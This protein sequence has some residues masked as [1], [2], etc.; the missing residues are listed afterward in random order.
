MSHGTIEMTGRKHPMGN[1]ACRFPHLPAIRPTFW[2]IVVIENGS[3]DNFTGVAFASHRRHNGSGGRLT[4]LPPCVSSRD[5]RTQLNSSSKDSK[6]SRSIGDKRNT[7]S[8]WQGNRTVSQPVSQVP[9]NPFSSHGPAVVAT[10]HPPYCVKERQT[11][12]RTGQ[13]RTGQLLSLVL[14]CIASSRVS[15]KTCSYYAIGN[16]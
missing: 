15:T 4:S 6:S 10:A 8:G 1:Y 11:G 5:I 12:G 3:R 14:P 16:Y 7:S 9:S 2:L 13:D